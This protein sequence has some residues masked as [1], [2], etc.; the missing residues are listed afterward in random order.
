[1]CG[2]TASR[3]EA[4]SAMGW[5]PID[6]CCKNVFCLRSAGLKLKPKKY[7]FLHEEGGL[8]PGTPS[9]QRR[10]CYRPWENQQSSRLACAEGR[11]FILHTDHGSLTWL[12]SFKEPEWQLVRWLEKL[13]EFNFSIVHCP[14]KSH[15]N[16]DA[17]SRLPCHQCRKEKDQQVSQVTTT[18]GPDPEQPLP[19]MQTLQRE[20][21]GISMVL[22]A[23]E[24]AEKPWR[25]GCAEST[26]PGNLL[27]VAALGT[28]GNL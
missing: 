4:T 10:D 21:P 2:Q 25:G 22:K 17:L 9:V 20:D 15:R 8:V 6:G 26:E 12:Q 19:D 28:A 7:T 11:E 23:K 5:K 16:A 3:G 1:M 13:Q 18:A 14:G 24:A 27:I